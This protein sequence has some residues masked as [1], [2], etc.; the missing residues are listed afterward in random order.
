[1][2]TEFLTSLIINASLLI[3]LS[4]VCH[5]LF[6]RNWK[7]NI[8][9]NISI[10]LVIGLIGIV[11]MMNS[12]V[13]STGIIFD[14][15]SILVSVMGLFFGFVP[16]IIAVV[17]ISVY[18]IF[19]G[20]SGALTGVLVTVLTAGI[21]LI[22]HQF[23]LRKILQEKKLAWLEFYL[24]GII[25]HMVMLGC[26]FSLPADKI[27]STLQ[28]IY[29][30]VLALYPLVAMILCMI[31]FYAL[32][33]V[34]TEEDL[35]A[36]ELRFRTMF[37]QA[38]IGI[39]IQDNHKTLYHNSM[40]EKI[41]GRTQDEIAAE[42]WENFTHPDDLRE[43]LDH[44]EQIWSGAINEYSMI[45][46]YYKPDGEI[47][48]ANLVVSSL[49]INSQSGGMYVCM[50]Q[51]ITQIKKTESDLKESE[52]NFKNL[53]HE[54]QEKQI[55]L[56]S[57]L[58][59][60]PA[61]IFY[62]DINGI[63]KNFNKAFQVAAGADYDS[64]MGHTDYDVFDKELAD[65]IRQ[66]D[67]TMVR[68]QKEQTVEELVCYPDGRKAYVETLIT[69][70]Y[71]AEG[72]LS[73]LIGTS[74]DI[75]ERKRK[76]EEIVFLNHH[77]VLT[78]LYNRTYFDDNVI[79][80]DTPE[81][82][83]LSVII[84][85]I[86]GLKFANDAFGHAKGDILLIEMAKILTSC[87][88]P[89]DIVARTGGDEF[90]ILLPGTDGAASQKIVDRIKRTCEEYVAQTEKE[91]YYTSISL[92]YETKTNA[93]ENFGDIQRLAEEH[94]Y[95]HKLLEHKSLHSAIISS[96]KTTMFEKSNETEEHAERMAELSKKLG[97]A[98]AFNENDLVSLELVT[99]L[100]DIGKISIDQAILDKPGPLSQDEW[101]EIK[102]H[103]DV[104]YRIAL[105]V[106]EL[107]RI[108]EYILCHHERWDGKGYPQQLA[109]TEI[110]L[111][112]RM[113]T[114]VDSYDAMTQDRA[115]RKAMSKDAAISELKKNAGTQFDPR[116]VEIFIDEVLEK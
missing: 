89:E 61:Q 59:T 41:L 25:T 108:A 72:Q 93:E 113:L 6:Y 38:P 14:T 31:A 116:I 92:G 44:L 18:R 45:K 47:V 49:R 84:G 88:R 26:M 54:Y 29:L 46:R 16:T 13:V 83:P 24:F 64:I 63:Y 1:M 65:H 52:A 106:P 21:G 40:Y 78:G 109:G 79:R 23:R 69:P 37:E 75:S 48:W 4:L 7:K 90:C 70:F 71:D 77:D 10:G 66:F 68:Q 12:V 73:G 58:N 60:I 43:D 100:H 91:T 19:L 101:A 81:Q 39:V 76:E 85:D 96:I 30:P 28:Y 111:I 9:F 87:C 8:L 51:D 95:R 74:R 105:T 22:W 80:F 115:Y 53:Y 82:L 3:S 11:L 86:N 99:T 5:T 2:D 97:T 36:S 110:P 57:L 32:K 17:I 102:K 56:Q 20:G 33:N 50:I 107:S 94:M 67:L 104:G 62:K 98:M 42:G 55:F 103:P 114:V 27:F 35:K 15:R 112:S 34:K